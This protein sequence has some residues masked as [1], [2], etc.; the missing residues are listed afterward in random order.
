MRIGLYAHGGSG[1]HG[2]E[3][4]VRSTIQ[5]LGEHEYLLFSERPE[6][7]LHYGLNQ[8]LCVV[9]SQSDFPK[10]LGRLAYSVEMKLRQDDSVYW[11]WRYRDFIRKIERL[12][13]ALAIGGDNYCYTGFTKRFSILNRA[14]VKKKVPIILWGCS[15]D[16]ERICPAILEDLRLYHLIFARESFTFETLKKEGFHNVNLMPDTAFLLNAKES[17]LPLGF[18][19]GNMVGLNISPLIISKEP[20]PGGVLLNC[21]KLIDF[22]LNRTEMSVALIPHVVWEGNDD[23]APLDIL[24]EEYG[25]SG[26]VIRIED[27]DAQT[28]KGIIRRC[29][30]LVAARTHA[31]IAGY[32][33]GVPT[34]VLGYSVKSRGIASDFFGTTNHFVLPVEEMKQGNELTDAFSWLIKHEKD[35]RAYYNCRLGDY[36]KGFNRFVL[37]GRV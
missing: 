24:Y 31:S 1:N 14:L 35:I 36:M 18:I 33:T 20:V 5:L 25:R 11:R 2:C 19:P 28:L 26:R 4:L 34:I 29:R 16:R 21:R 32:S 12:D 13:I 27:A 8:Q 15:I 10:G 30:F 9:P 3:A 6:E 7:D 22:I 23:R 17:S 37:N